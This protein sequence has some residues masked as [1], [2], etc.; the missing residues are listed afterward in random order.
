M[1]GEIQEGLALAARVLTVCAS[2]TWV[3]TA[4]APA[5]CVPAACVLTARAP[6]VCVP[7]I[8][9]LTVCVLAAGDAPRRG[10][11]LGRDGGGLP[12]GQAWLVTLSPGGFPV[13]R[14][15]RC[16]PVAGNRVG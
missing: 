2:V 4:R 3:L 6:A 12:A 14:A 9:V 5:V 7:A 11:R 8:C 10:F 16:G 15:F 1:V 13:G